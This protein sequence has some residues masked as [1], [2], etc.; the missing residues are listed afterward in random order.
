MHS[1]GFTERRDDMTAKEMATEFLTTM[2]PEL[3]NDG[4]TNFAIY[5]FELPDE[6]FNL[7]VCFIEEDFDDEREFRTAIDLVS[8]HSTTVDYTFAETMT[9]IDGIADG[10]QY[11][12]D[13]YEVKA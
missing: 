10:I 2:N 13:K 9:D 6:R 4:S 5:E 8:K 11:L 7:E 12:L 1:R 3:R